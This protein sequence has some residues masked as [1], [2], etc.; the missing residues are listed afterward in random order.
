MAVYAGNRDQL[1]QAQRVKVV[2]LHGGVAHLVAL[3]YRNNH[4]LAAAAQHGRHFLV[5]CRHTGAHVHHHHDAVRCIN[6]QLR[7][8]AD[9]AYN[10]VIPLRLDA[11]GI[12]QQH[13]VVQPLAVAEDPVP[14]N[15][16][17]ILHNGKALAHQLVEQG[18]FAHIGA[19]YYCNDRQC[20]A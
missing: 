9:V 20:H 7:L 8:L 15:T 2:Q 11:A 16:G 1:T 12:N 19:P 6:G 14:G 18:G 13:F 10:A 4:R 5:L 3:V 17:G